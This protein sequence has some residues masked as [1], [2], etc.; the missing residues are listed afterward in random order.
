MSPARQ[1]LLRLV[2]YAYW[3]VGADETDPAMKRVFGA[4][5]DTAQEELKRRLAAFRG[6]SSNEVH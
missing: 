5:S 2:Q 4:L 3:K 6:R 1:L